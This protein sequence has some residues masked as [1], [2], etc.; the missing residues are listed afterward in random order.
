MH[1][2]PT[3]GSNASNAHPARATH[4]K[5]EPV[6][7]LSSLRHFRSM[8]RAFK[9]ADTSTAAERRPA[10]SA[11][12][13][14]RVCRWHALSTFTPHA[15]SAGRAH[16]AAECDRASNAAHLNTL[17]RTR[18]RQRRL[19]LPQQ[20]SS[21]ICTEQLFAQ[22]AKYCGSAKSRQYQHG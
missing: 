12:H 3:Q 13:D 5:D 1:C 14:S 20:T 7:E 2:S 9:P 4:T 22:Q 18:D 21:C 10:T 15:A 17:S 8:Q 6:T 19:S 16:A 11:M